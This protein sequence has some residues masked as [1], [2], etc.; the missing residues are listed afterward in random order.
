VTWHRRFDEEC[1]RASSS[2]L[3]NQIQ[4]NSFHSSHGLKAM[5]AESS[6]IGAPV[7]RFGDYELDQRTL[8]LRKSGQKIKLAPQPARVLIMLASLPGKLVSRDEIR[9]AL[10]GEETFVD[11]ERNLNYCLNCIRDALDDTAQSPRY[12]ETL[13]RRGYRFIA[14]IERQRPFA[15]P[16]LAV[17]PFANLNGDPAR[18]YFAD[19]ITDA[20]ITELARIKALRVISRQSVLHLKGSSRKVDEIALELRVDGIVEGAVLHEGNRVRVTAQLILLEPERHAWAESY[21]CDM[22]A[23]LTTQRE[24]ARAI[25]ACVAFALRP[26]AAI[27]R[28]A[29]PAGPESSGW[30]PE[31]IETYLKAL[32]ELGKMNAEGL[33]KSL[34][35][36]RELTTKAPDF[37]LGLAGHASCLFALGWWGHAPARE[38]YPSAKAMLSK[39]I[40]LDDNLSAAHMM[41]AFMI[42]LLDLDLAAAEREFRRAIVLSPSNAEAHIFI[43]VFLCWLGRYSESILEA[44]YGLRLNP[45]SLIPNQA[46]AWTYLHAGYPE[47]AEALARQTIELFPD[48]LQLHFVLGWSAWC[49]DRPKEAIAIFEKALALSREAFSLSFLGHAYARLGRRDEAMNLLQELNQ[50]SS[51]GKASPMGLVVLHAGLGNID[52]AFEWLETALHLR[53]DLPWLFTKFPGLD[54]LRLDPR[55][56]AL[57]HSVRVQT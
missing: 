20:L 34:Q 16:T 52:A 42:W 30:T 4:N 22:A 57:E 53:D 13:P 9:R 35:Y 11:F 40:A 8:E 10:W 25:A 43:A 45:T 46:A 54:P 12:I 26:E 23:V 44:E 3:K 14:P 37:A 6:R 47:K 18:E 48:A 28:T 38:V 50:L 51:Q 31:I 24:A 55:F 15:E 7:C 29:V 5:I 41:L 33:E 32:S 19:G 21:D 39:A 27:A 56:A 2:L 36:Y 17:L 49:Q 1:S